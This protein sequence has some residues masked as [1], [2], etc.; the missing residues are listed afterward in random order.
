[1]P[2]TNPWLAG[3]TPGLDLPREQVFGTARTPRARRPARRP[4]LG[5]PAL[6]VRPRRTRPVPARATS[7]PADGA[8][9]HPHPLHRP[10]A[11]PDG[12]PP[13]ADVAPGARLS[14]PRPRSTGGSVHVPPEGL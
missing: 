12:P 2:L 4:V 10:L 13:P 3:P 6:A 1:M 8:D 9:P 14:A 11:A 7:R 5:G